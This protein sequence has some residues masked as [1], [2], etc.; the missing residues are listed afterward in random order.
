MV[1]ERHGGDVQ[2]QQ[3]SP[4][5]APMKLQLRSIPSQLFAV[6]PNG[7]H[8]FTYQVR[9]KGE[10]A[11]H[12]VLTQATTSAYAH[13]LPYPLLIVSLRRAGQPAPPLRLIPPEGDEFRLYWRRDRRAVLH[14]LRLQQV[15]LAARPR[16]RLYIAVYPQRSWWAQAAHERPVQVRLRV[17]ECAG[18]GSAR[19]HRKA[20]RDV[21]GF[22]FVLVLPLVLGTLALL[23]VFTCARAWARIRR[24]SAGLGAHDRL[25]PAETEM[26]FPRFA[27]L[28]AHGAAL[29]GAG[30]PSCVICL[31]P[32]E[33]A[34]TLRRLRCGHSYHANCLDE[35]LKTNASCPRCRKPARIRGRMLWMTRIMAI[36]GNV[37]RWLRAR[38]NYS[39]RQAVE[40][41]DV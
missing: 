37:V 12:L 23:T 40:E 14:R 17:V 18:R 38:I 16:D 3:P 28:K 5:K 21:G 39:T 4:T 13:L 29:D 27:Y 34:D 2:Q 30:E 31:N 33:E 35:W 32:Y 41:E 11:V 20:P 26:M 6:P 15:V 36:R 24:R 22:V 25:T 19:C 9:V 10:V 1:G 7:Q 8:F